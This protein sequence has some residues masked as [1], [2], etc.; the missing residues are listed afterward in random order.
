MS[1][2]SEENEQ[3]MADLARDIKAFAARRDEREIVDLV[4]DV[5]ALVLVGDE[6]TH[7]DSMQEGARAT[8][9]PEITARLRAMRDVLRAR[10]GGE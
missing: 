6:I 2:L 4:K 10:R 3:I 8:G 1:R 5:E 7:A 9:E